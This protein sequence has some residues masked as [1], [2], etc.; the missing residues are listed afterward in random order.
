MV[1]GEERDT[2][3][4]GWTHGVGHFVHPPTLS[5]VSP[6]LSTSGMGT[7]RKTPSAKL[8]LIVG[9]GEISKQRPAVLVP[10]GADGKALTAQP[11]EGRV[12]PVAQELQGQGLH[13]ES[14]P[15]RAKEREGVC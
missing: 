15:P 7:K 3:F 10:G 11:G 13:W 1:Q 2:I 14:A 8:P 4:F 6:F 12:S 5:A 9:V